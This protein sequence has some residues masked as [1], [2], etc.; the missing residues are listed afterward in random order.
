MLIEWKGEKVTSMHDQGGL[1]KNK[2]G[3]SHSHE[4]LWL[5]KGN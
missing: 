4:G 1:G 5:S 2:V 3:A